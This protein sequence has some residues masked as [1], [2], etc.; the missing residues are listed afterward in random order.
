MGLTHEV[1]VL[2]EDDL[3]RVIDVL[4]SVNNGDIYPVNDVTKPHIEAIIEKIDA[5]L[6]TG[7]VGEAY[8]VWMAGLDT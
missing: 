2:D 6:D 7:W 5:E 4:L 1:P 8:T 3:R